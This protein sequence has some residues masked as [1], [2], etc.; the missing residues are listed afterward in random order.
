MMEFLEIHEKSPIEQRVKTTFNF[1][2][3]ILL[4]PTISTDAGVAF[5]HTC[6]STELGE[7]FY[8]RSLAGVDYEQIIRVRYP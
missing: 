2:F 8:S 6:I 4:V 7:C 1:K 3:F 5:S